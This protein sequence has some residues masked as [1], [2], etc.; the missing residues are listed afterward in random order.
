VDLIVRGACCLRPGVPGL[1]ENIH[2]RSIIGRFLEHSRIYSF[3]NGGEPE[4]YAGSADLMPRNIDRRVETLFPVE[5]PE[6]ISMLRD[7]VLELA[8]ADNQMARVLDAE[9][10]YTRL[11]PED[12]VPALSYQQAMAERRHGAG[13]KQKR[14]RF[15]V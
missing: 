5:D 15:K 10:S 7:E 13:R 3:E 9:G 11:K 6:A 2:V 8:L 1:S 12:G 14:G 4:V